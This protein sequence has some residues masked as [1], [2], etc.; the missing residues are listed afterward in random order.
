MWL[1]QRM[2]QSHKNFTS[3]NFPRKQWVTRLPLLL[4][5]TRSGSPQL[6]WRKKSQGGH[7]KFAKQFALM[8]SEKRPELTLSQAGWTADPTF[9][10]QV[11]IHIVLRASVNQS[12]TK[13]RNLCKKKTI[14]GAPAS[15]EEPRLKKGQG[16]Y[17]FHIAVK[18]ECWVPS[19]IH[20]VKFL[21][22]WRQ[23]CWVPSAIH[24]VKFLPAWRQMCWVPFI[25]SSFFQLEDKCAECYSS[26]SSFFQL[27]D[28]GRRFRSA[29]S[30]YLNVFA[31]W[32]PRPL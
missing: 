19:A 24:W 5:W 7:E 22:A 27:E 11:H 16:S 26:E 31:P 9:I 1:T 15:T 32:H 29:L 2:Q 8:M 13:E 3:W 30:L 10:I 18:K 20:W 25:G 28:T 6:V 23:V 14:C 4:P 12:I 17:L 21:P